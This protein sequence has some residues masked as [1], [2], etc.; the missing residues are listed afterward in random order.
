MIPLGT[1][2]WIIYAP[3]YPRAVGKQCVVTAHGHYG[4]CE[5]GTQNCLVDIYGD[6]SGVAAG[7]KCLVPIAPLPP[8][9]TVKRRKREKV[10]A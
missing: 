3:A 5:L 6:R 10:P 1:V 2:C 9:K 4:T 8:A 7:F